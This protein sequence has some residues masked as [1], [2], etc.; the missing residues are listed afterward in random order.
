[1]LWAAMNKM[2]SKVKETVGT[3]NNFCLQIAKSKKMI[4]R[5]RAQIE[6]AKKENVSLQSSL[7]S[8]LALKLEEAE[9][10]FSDS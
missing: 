7:S 6:L 4:A 10:D 2:D 9:S 5:F 1:M 8:V 3:I